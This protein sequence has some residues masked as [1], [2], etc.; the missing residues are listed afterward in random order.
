MVSAWFP[1]LV[2][3]LVCYPTVFTFSV[4][5]LDKFSYSFPVLSFCACATWP[6]TRV[7]GLPTI[8]PITH[9]TRYTPSSIFKS[10]CPF[11]LFSFMSSMKVLLNPNDWEEPAMCVLNKRTETLLPNPYLINLL[12]NLC[13]FRHQ[14]LIIIKCLFDLGLDSKVQFSAPADW[15]SESGHACKM[16]GCVT[17]EN[18]MVVIKFCFA[19]QT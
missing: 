10:Y 5:H 12:F 3:S 18:R 6:M 15:T 16:F 7:L 17:A 19:S 9:T 11:A 4:S 1:S 2:L 8:T 14:E 13:F